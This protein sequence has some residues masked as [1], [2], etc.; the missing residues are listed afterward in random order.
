MDDYEVIKRLDRIQELLEL[1]DKALQVMANR[2]LANGEHLMRIEELVR[3]LLKPGLA[4]D[5]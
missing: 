5:A 1:H 2:V 3:E 4:Y